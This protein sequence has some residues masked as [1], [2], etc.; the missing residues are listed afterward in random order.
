MHPAP[1]L[2]RVHVRD[3]RG[4]RRHVRPGRPAVAEARA[5]VGRRAEPGQQHAGRVLPAAVR[6]G[7]TDGPAQRAVAC[8][9]C[10]GLASGRHRA[11][12]R[13]HPS[14]P[15]PWTQPGSRC[16]RGHRIR[17]GPGAG[18][19]WT[20]PPAPG[21]ATANPVTAQPLSWTAD[22]TDPRVPALDRVRGHHA[23]APARHH[24]TRGSLRG[25]GRCQLRGPR[26]GQDRPDRVIRSSPRTAR[27]SS[28]WRAGHAGAVPEVTEF[29]ARTGQPVIPSPAGNTAS[30]GPRTC[31][32]TTRPAAR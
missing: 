14:S 8:G 2:P 16:S 21:S 11:V 32:G 30:L 7:R 13:R 20:W 22:G 9:R 28:R 1:S 31:S 23:G 15:P 10:S 29:S 3:R 25:Q 18:R 26:P 19:R 6:R 17:R 24:G 5:D 12:A 4:G 27:R